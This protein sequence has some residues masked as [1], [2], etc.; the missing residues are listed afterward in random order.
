VKIVTLMT[1]AGFFLAC[2]AKVAAD[3]PTRAQSP[4]K[5]LLAIASS[6]TGNSEIFL[7]NPDNGDIK[8]LT[9]HPASD[10]DPAWSPCGKQLA[11]VSDRDGTPNLYLMNVDGSNVRQ[12]TKEKVTCTQPHWSPDGK[13]IAF[14]SAKSGLNDIFVVEAQ[15]GGIKQL[16]REPFT[17][18]QPAWSPDGQ[19]L[20]YSYYIAGPYETFVMNA[21]GSGKT[22]LSRGGGLDAAWSPDGKKIAFTSVR[23]HKG[24]FRLYIMDP[25]GGNVTALSTNDNTCGCV[26][27]AWS[28]DGKRI[29]FTDM[30]AGQ[31]QVAVVGAQGEGYRQLNHKGSS[32]GAQ[33]SPDGKSITF[34]RTEEN[35]PSA[36][37]ICDSDGQHGRELLRG[38]GSGPW[39]P[40]SNIPTPRMPRVVRADSKQSGRKGPGGG[41]NYFSRP[42]IAATPEEA[43]L[44]AFWNDYYDALKRYYQQL[45]Q[46]DWVQYYKQGSRINGGFGPDGWPGCPRIQFAPVFVSPEMPWAVPG[47]SP[48]KG[49]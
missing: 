49:P 27:P 31:L 1:L 35:Q 22:N 42:G 10:S 26:F 21:D 40:H 36:L 34:V 9:N 37:W 39:Q 24:G 46:I 47:G 25:D 41:P 30:I 28:P 2:H 32:L 23:A 14:V 8:N 45:D 6:H 18:G 19:K 12:L 15:T 3:E 4:P 13:R 17:C 29:V 7:L 33:W 44:Q 5:R 48:G 38:C 11:F 43:R 20:T 16:T